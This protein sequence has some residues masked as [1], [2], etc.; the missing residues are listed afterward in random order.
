MRSLESQMIKSATISWEFKATRGV[1]DLKQCL[2]RNPPGRVQLER[3]RSN[4]ELRHRVPPVTECCP[5]E[6][7]GHLLRA[8]NRETAV[9]GNSAF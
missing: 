6:V 5:Q 2:P 8:L 7:V 3:E 9:T 4:W 1:A